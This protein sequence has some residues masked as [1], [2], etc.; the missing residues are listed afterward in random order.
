G[1]EG[2]RS[3]IRLTPSP[4]PLPLKAGGE[5]ENHLSLWA[6]QGSP[7]CVVRLRR[8]AA[9]DAHLRA[10][11]PPRRPRRRARVHPR[12]TSNHL[13][14]VAPMTRLILPVVLLAAAAALVALPGD[15][16]GCGVAPHEGQYVAVADESALIVWD[17]ATKTEH[18]VRRAR[19]EG[20][21]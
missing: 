11:L 4:R 13:R 5:E 8:D 10:R 17:E 14:G 18:F 21:A 19:F 12:R 20:T 3:C 1:G 2:S 9:G 16:P 15:A 6:I 7:R